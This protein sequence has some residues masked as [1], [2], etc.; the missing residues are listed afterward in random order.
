MDAKTFDGT[1]SNLNWNQESS[2]GFFK[3]FTNMAMFIGLP[4]I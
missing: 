2:F 3:N 1:N 4:N